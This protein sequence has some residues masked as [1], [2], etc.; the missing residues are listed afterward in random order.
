MNKDNDR[1]YSLIN[2]FL[3]IL[4]G[5]FLFLISDLEEYAFSCSKSR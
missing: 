1:F 2:D 4:S 3:H 5:H